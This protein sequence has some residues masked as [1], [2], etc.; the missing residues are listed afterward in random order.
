MQ[1][2]R[3]HSLSCLANAMFCIVESHRSLQYITYTMPARSRQ[4]RTLNNTAQDNAPGTAHS[5]IFFLRRIDLNPGQVLCIYSADWT[6][7]RNFR[8]IY[9]DGNCASFYSGWPL[10]LGLV[11]FLLELL[12][13]QSEELALKL[14]LD[15]AKACADRDLRARSVNATFIVFYFGIILLYAHIKNTSFS[16]FNKRFLGCR[17]QI[18]NTIF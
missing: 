13:R 5:N 18:C 9:L 3:L 4:C 6:S 8:S 10:T 1:T 14:L 11:C 7:V 12:I 2:K 15:S 17:F 16:F